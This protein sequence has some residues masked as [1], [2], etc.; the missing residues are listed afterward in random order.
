MPPRTH[1][2]VA[3]AA[4]TVARCAR[5]L[6][7]GA[8]QR[9]QEGRQ[10][11]RAWVTTPI[12]TARKATS[13]TPA[14]IARAAPESGGWSADSLGRR[15]VADRGVAV[16][17]KYMSWMHVVQE[18]ESPN[19]ISKARKASRQHMPG[20]GMAAG[21]KG[22]FV[23]GLGRRAASPKCTTPIID[24][25]PSPN[26]P[27]ARDAGMGHLGGGPF[28]LR[29]RCRSRSRR[30]KVTAN[31]MVRYLHPGR[32]PPKRS[33]SK[34]PN[35]RSATRHRSRSS[36]PHYAKKCKK[37]ALE[38]EDGANLRSECRPSPSE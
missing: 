38:T 22:A 23:V 27:A 18:E 4:R 21:T 14:T 34:A 36:T 9:A 6:G 13:A 11:R 25:R 15:M 30:G 37:L 3:A 35:N 5:R 26:A 10:G 17:R 8:S 20:Y 19:E 16:E 24:D 28:L 1:F 12:C 33:S 7:Q 2:C 32:S 29:R 31:P